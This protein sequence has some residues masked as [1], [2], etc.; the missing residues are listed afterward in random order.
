MPDALAADTRAV[1]TVPAS[2]PRSALAAT[3]ELRG[4]AIA[5][6][7]I[8][9]PVEAVPNAP[10]AAH[11]GVDERWILERT[12]ITERRIA[13]PDE[14]VSALGREAAQ[15]ALA[16]ASVE[17]SELD[18]ILVATMS[19][20]RVMPSAS[21]LIAGELGAP[22]AAAI[23]LNAACTGFV[24]GLVLAAGQL[25]SGRA[26]AILVIG[27]D[28][29]SPLTDP[30]DRRTAALFGD[31]A[32]A[33]VIT[34]SS[35]PSRVGPASVGSDGARSELIT[36]ERDELVIRMNGHDTFR[37]AVDRLAE[38]TLAACEGAGLAL[39]EIDV[40]AY[41]QANARILAAVGERLGLDPARVINCIDRYGNT[42]AAT[43]PLAL[44]DASE[45]GM[46]GD[47]AQVL[48][49]AFG[50]G[51]TWAATVVEWG[52]STVHGAETEGEAR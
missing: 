39:E 28:V 37:Q 17:A 26:E 40:F 41:H 31:A 19:H 44:A 16:A 12:G 45:R 25:E 46:L 34:G 29:L 30:N 50:G 43:I 51:L 7:G 9:I 20:E 11:L 8:A 1:D 10:I 6:L 42:S 21:A 15:R 24:S 3:P 4:A 35:S 5:G 14:T 33:A 49:A 36:A 48:V 32:G 23:D 52:A 22:Q 47:G 18:M 2:E 13:G 38:S 27:A